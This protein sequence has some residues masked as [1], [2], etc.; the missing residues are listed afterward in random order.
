MPSDLRPPG[1]VGRP[2][3]AVVVRTCVGDRKVEIYD[4]FHTSATYMP[5]TGFVAIKHDTHVHFSRHRP[6]GQSFLENVE[7]G[8]MAPRI[9]PG[10]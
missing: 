7:A 3:G 5:P 6:P 9:L 4:M 2:A 10:S 1:S 8:Y